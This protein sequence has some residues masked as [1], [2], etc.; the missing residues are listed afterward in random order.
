M[1]LVHTPLML[2]WALV[3]GQGGL[4]GDPVV[5][6]VPPEVATVL[7]RWLQPDP[8]QQ[9]STEYL[10]WACL[11]A[12]DYYWVGCCQGA[13]GSLEKGVT[14]NVAGWPLDG[15]DETFDP[16]ACLGNRV[17]VT[18]G[19]PARVDCERPPVASDEPLRNLAVELL[20]HLVDGMVRGCPVLVAT[21]KELL[22][23][24]PSLDF[25]VTAAAFARAGLP[26]RLRQ[27]CRVR[28]PSQNPG[29]FL[30]AEGADLLVIPTD[31]TEPA[32][33]A[34]R[35]AT[36]LD[37]RGVRQVGSEPAPTAR[38]YALAVWEEATRFPQGLTAFGARF[39]RLWDGAW[40]LPQS[41]VDLIPTVFKLGVAL[42][43]SPQQRANLFAN[44]LIERAKNAELPWRLLISDDEWRTFPEDR[45]TAYLL[46][47]PG[48]LTAG[49]LALQRAIEGTFGVG[50]VRIDSGVHSWWDREDAAKRSRLLTL[51][52]STP[53]LISP[54]LMASLFGGL[55]LATLLGDGP[56][57]G[58]LAAE[59]DAGTLGRRATEAATLTFLAADAAVTG[60]LC[61]AAR[62]GL[63]DLSW[64]ARVIEH[65]EPA[66]MSQV[67]L[68]LASYPEESA[69]W[70]ET[71][72]RLIAAVRGLPQVDG[73]TVL[74]LAR[75]AEGI[76]PAVHPGVYFGLL[77]LV[78]AAEPAPGAL[79]SPLL[80]RL[81]PLLDVIGDPV[82][83]RRVAAELLGGHWTC[84]GPGLLIDT[85]GTL[86]P[87]WLHTL[88]DLLLA[89]PELMVTMTLK[90]LIR[91]RPGRRGDPAPWA[92]A[93]TKRWRGDPPTVTDALIAAD[94]WYDWRRH[95]V[96]D[97]GE[98][99]QSAMSWLVAPAW[100][101]HRAAGPEGL[102]PHWHRGHGRAPDRRP[103]ECNWEAWRQVMIDLDTGLAAV[104]VRSITAPPTHWPWIYSREQEQV[105]DLEARCLDTEGRDWLRQA[106][107]RDT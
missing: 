14:V 60:I 6:T 13:G 37:R 63:L 25:L 104:H 106:A 8:N 51:A 102:P 42:H 62:R 50:G 71:T 36:I 79:S 24:G 69:S 26:T 92:A 96:L 83:R 1:P 78:C 16:G 80:E 100:V 91:M 43:G 22:C 68:G 99:H 34:C 82:A 33:I 56:V 49:E 97:P 59:L 55:S 39:D 23:L 94:A 19:S 30:G 2:T 11:P 45:L 20:T 67:L 29:R 27:R 52:R 46:R 87:A 70:G 12:G 9:D 17:A 54:T 64:I 10:G 88:P 40:P 86:R 77:D 105:A 103:P 5:G 84:P 41:L 3:P 48:G 57:S 74:T 44:H 76:D 89:S 61:R 28:I 35:D 47:E 4:D 93:V 58:L 18:S 66:T 73:A 75:I 7:T 90:E 38:A 72:E 101:H 21:T 107:A 81:W 31:Q 98:G 95:A 15:C 32:L 53:T 85:S 65:G